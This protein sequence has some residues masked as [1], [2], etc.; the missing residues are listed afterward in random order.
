[1]PFTFTAEGSKQVPHDAPVAD[2]MSSD[3]I[4]VELETGIDE[5]IDLMID[6]KVGAVPVVDDRGVLVGI[7]SYVDLLNELRLAIQ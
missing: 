7:V 1:M 3:V 6:E 2:L 4:S 5:I